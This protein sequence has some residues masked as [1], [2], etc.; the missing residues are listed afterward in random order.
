MFTNALG[1]WLLIPLLYIVNAG[2]SGH[3]WVAANIDDGHLDY[4]FFVL[5]ALMLLDQV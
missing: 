3:E 1:T 5:C 2:G 4:Y